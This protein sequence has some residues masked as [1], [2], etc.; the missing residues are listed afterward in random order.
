LSFLKNHSVIFLG[1]D[2][3]SPHIPCFYDTFKSCI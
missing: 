1:G 2:Q 3:R